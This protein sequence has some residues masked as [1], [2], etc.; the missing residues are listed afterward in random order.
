MRTLLWS[1]EARQGLRFQENLFLLAARLSS[2]E[3]MYLRNWE[4]ESSEEFL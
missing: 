3:E 1:P 4:R 2:K